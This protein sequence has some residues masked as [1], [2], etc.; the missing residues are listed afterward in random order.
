MAHAP[1]FADAILRIYL[2]PSLVVHDISG[3][4]TGDH[5]RT[6]ERGYLHALSTS[7]KGIVGIALMRPGTPVATEEARAE[8][9]R[10]TKE[11]GTRVSRVAMVV[12]GS[13]VTATALRTV[14]RAL[15]ILARGQSL[16]V[17][18]RPSEG[19]QA[20]A[21]IL[22]SLTGKPVDQMALLREIEA[23]RSAAPAAIAS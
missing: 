13:G 16:V 12:E 18:A 11:L 19:V 7:H 10:F 5:M 23:T 3:K 21:P 8:G 6:I 2:W 9:A 20:V 17:C 15:N 14:I 4:L 1:F 22:E